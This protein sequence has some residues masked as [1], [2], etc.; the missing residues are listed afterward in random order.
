MSSNT[1]AAKAGLASSCA[2]ERAAAV[3]LVSVLLMKFATASAH[4]FICGMHVWS[5]VNS[6]PQLVDMQHVNWALLQQ[7]VKQFL[8]HGGQF[9]A[10][11]CDAVVSPAV[12]PLIVM[13][14]HALRT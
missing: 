2:L 8:L 13:L 9:L 3:A 10:V 12:Q 11:G 7:A 1:C 4:G 6:L 14:T 5:V